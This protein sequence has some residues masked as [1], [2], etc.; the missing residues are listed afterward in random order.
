MLESIK[1]LSRLFLLQAMYFG[2]L[3]TMIY[4]LFKRA[5][6]ALFLFAALISQPN[7]WYKLADMPLGKDF[8]DLI[9]LAAFFGILLNKQPITKT[10]NLTICFIF[11]CFSFFSLLNSCEHFSLGLPVSLDHPLVKPWK[12]YAI[13]VLLYALTLSAVKTERHQKI[14]VYIMILVILHISLRSYR[15]FSGGGSFVED[16]RY[17]GPFWIVGLGSNHLGAF[18]ADYSIFTLGLFFFEKNPRR[19]VLCIVTVLFSLH[20]LFF[21]Y[22]R[23]AYAAAAFA[24]LFFGIIKKRTL[25]LL[26]VG[27]FLAWQTLL[28]PSVV[29]RINMTQNESGQ[30][31]RSAAARLE[32]WDAAVVLFEQNPLFGVGFD[33]FRLSREGEHWTDTHNYFLKKLSEE[34]I[35]GLLL[36]IILYLRC[37]HSAFRLLKTGKSSF[38]QGLAFG[39]LGCTSAHII[40]NM[41]GDRFTWIELGAFFFMLWALVDR[42]VL[43][44]QKEIG[45]QPNSQPIYQNFISKFLSA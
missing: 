24:L 38:Q 41:F 14:L 40:T 5:E 43:L 25:L 6:I 20:P 16:S 26:L 18:I 11:L 8:T 15:S 23:G 44:S 4:A 3:G 31:E 9:F 32:L 29:D 45:E 17:A 35:V 30:L 1:L 19:K 10:G 12:N 34:G 2:G 7:I 37:Y 36:L 42:G 22:S 21:S 27:L 28:P 33:G 39:F 13:M